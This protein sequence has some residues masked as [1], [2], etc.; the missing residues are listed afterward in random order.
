MVN[1]PA[2]YYQ[3]DDVAQ[4]YDRE[5]FS[6]FAGRAFN[7][8]EKHNIRRAFSVLDRNAVIA[9]VPCGT[10]RLAEVLLNDGFR[11]VGLDISDAMLEVARRR[12]ARFGDRF[13]SNVA[14]MLDPNFLPTQRFE[15]VLCARVLM[16]F[17]LPQQ[18]LFL[19]NAARLADNRIV[20]TQSWV[21]PY[22]RLRH[23][24]KELLRR[25]SSVNYPISSADLERLL[26]GAGLKEVK[27][28]RPCA[29]LT[30]EVIVVC[31]HIDGQREGL[32]GA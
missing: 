12:L 21:S 31:A 23:R 19:R 18:I 22:Q 5:R 11:V 26:S 7:A 1:D 10:G 4:T 2:H 13:S 15:A 8:L 29:P 14:D 20:F 30:E 25:P 28:I 32:A 24:V 17:P 16:H 3:N 27:R 9:D 6:T